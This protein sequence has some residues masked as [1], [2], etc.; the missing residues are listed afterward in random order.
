MTFKA[1]YRLI[2]TPPYSWCKRGRRV[3]GEY[4]GSEPGVG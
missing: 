4:L 2:I 1:L 3:G